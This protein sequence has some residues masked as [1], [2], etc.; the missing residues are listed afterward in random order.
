MTKCMGSTIIE[1][2]I[3]LG[4]T[5][6]CISPGSRS[7]PLTQ[8]LALSSHAKK[9][10]FIDER[11][12]AFFAL[13]LGKATGKAAVMITTS[14]T[15]VSNG[16]PAL[17]EASQSGVPILFIS[18]D[19]PPELRYS[20]ANQTIDQV[21]LF[22]DKVRYFA[23]ISPSKSNP[24]S[25]R[26]IVSE[27]IYHCSKSENK[28]PAHINVM[29]REPFSDPLPPNEDSEA[30]VI[31]EEPQRGL[32]SKQIDFI[33]ENVNKARNPLLIIGNIEDPIER[34]AALTL[35]NKLCWP[36]IC[37]VSSG[38]SLFDIKHKISLRMM[39]A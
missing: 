16:F 38:L 3:S 6:F 36:T 2:L 24:N 28:G 22:S 5:D 35:A 31:W 4:I 14:G 32:S 37:D 8:A 10:V 26:S 15:A 33:S 17:I 18:S 27:A 23:D 12:S 20:G 21:K 29:F 13:G 11:S 25:V 1:E 30:L 7:T 9:Y 34:K 39:Y 19:R